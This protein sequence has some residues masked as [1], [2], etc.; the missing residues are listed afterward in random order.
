MQLPN[1]ILTYLHGIFYSF[2]SNNCVNLS[3][4]VDK[5]HDYINRTLSSNHNWHSLLLNTALRLFNISG[6]YLII[7]EVVVAK[8]YSKRIDGT[9]WVFSPI[10]KYAFRGFSLIVLAWSNGDGICI[11]IAF[12]IRKKDSDNTKIDVA[13]DLLQ[14]AHDDLEIKPE[15][16]L[17]DSFFSAAKMLQ[18]ISNLKWKF[19]SQIKSNRKFL[20]KGVKKHSFRPYWTKSG[21][22]AGVQV[23]VVRHGKKYFC[24]ND[25]SLGH[26]QV[27]KLYK[28]RWPIEE[29][30]RFTKQELGLEECQLRTPGAQEAHFAMCFMGYMLLE[31]ESELKNVTNYKIREELTFQRDS[32]QVQAFSLLFA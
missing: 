28:K 7:D 1:S 26:Q 9:T 20:G 14:W 23:V 2:S 32:V 4:F 19:C 25:T 3:K 10:Y 24:T 5:S 16:V 18:L 12:K 27:R 6:G 11:P 29:I 21:E 30:F 15:A 13:M 17:F 31:K 8:R 22:M